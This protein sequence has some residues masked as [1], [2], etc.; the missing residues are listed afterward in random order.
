M[1]PHRHEV[2]PIHSADP[3][4]VAALLPS[5]LQGSTI[6]VDHPVSEP[7]LRHLDDL[8]DVYHCWNPQLRKVA[9]R[10]RTVDPPSR[11]QR[12]G[13]FY[14]GGVNSN[15][16]FLRHRDEIDYLIVIS[17]FDFE[18]ARDTFD[19]VIARLSPIA[20]SFRKTLLPIE[21]NFFQ[22]ER[23]C[24]LHRFLSHGSSLAATALS[25]GFRRVYIPSSHTYRELGPWGSHPLTDRMWTNEC[26]ELV[27]DGA[28]FRRT[29]KL[30]EMAGNKQLIDNLIVCWREPNRNCGECGKC[31]RTMTAFRLL[32][33][34]SPVVRSSIRC[35]LKGSTA[36][37]CD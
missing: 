33:I 24:R 13:S 32:G 22:F 15:H 31:L 2:E 4:V 17:G 14:S 8:Q 5:M 3:F 25:L 30:R 29:E 26:T 21:T 10:C 20:G 9:I 23:A 6:D 1:V 34:S 12:V 37:G 7:L 16:T 36:T 28:G 18:M 27:H 11:V 35:E 19:A